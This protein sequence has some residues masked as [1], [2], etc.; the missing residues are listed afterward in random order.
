MTH[1]E[2]YRMINRIAYKSRPEGGHSMDT[3][4][5]FDAAQTIIRMESRL[6][7]REVA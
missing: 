2:A 6:A 1:D 3:L 4:I 5:L 7:G